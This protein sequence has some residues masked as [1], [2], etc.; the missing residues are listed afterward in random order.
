MRIGSVLIQNLAVQLA[1]ADDPSLH[2]RP[3]VIGGLPFEAKPVYDASPQVI[4]CGV[5]VGMPLREAY[6]LCPTAKFL[7]SAQA[8]YEHIF[9]QV[10][11]VLER[12]SPV[13]DVEK[14]GCAYIDITGVQDEANLCQDMFRNICA[15]TGLRACLGVS[16]GKFFSYVAAF[17]SKPGNPVILSPGQEN[18]FVASF[19]AGFLACSDESKERLYLLG[20][21]F[22]G[23]L[24]QFSRAALVAQFGGDGTLMHDLARG[25]DR[26]PLIPRAKP[27]MIANSV[28][29]DYPAVS[30]VEI[31]QVCEVMLRRL[32]DRAKEQG[33][34]CREVCL[35]L[36][37]AS[38]MLQERKLSL[39]EPTTSIRLILSRLQTWLETVRLSSG[40][41]E[42]GLSLSLTGEQVRKLSLWLDKQRA[43]EGLVKAAQ[44]LKLR[45]G[46]QPIK[47]SR[48]VNPEPI[49]PERRFTL[50]D[51]LE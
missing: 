51:A 10:A 16:G 32:L 46:Y 37:S 24:T 43:E 2:G 41:E 50:N 48:A 40:V 17:T 11:G 13:V 9:E 3:V 7:P 26:C 8:R 1:L 42:V 14:L 18:D 45:F 12:F 38:G 47:K 19:S 5:K 39:R 15:E 23:E 29:L 20:I 31:L 36:G 22:I 34:L 28:T 25:I 4:A 21:R 35:R 49:L 30:Y 6:A 33:K 27:E 44:E